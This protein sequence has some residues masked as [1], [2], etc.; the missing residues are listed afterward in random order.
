MKT[1]KLYFGAAYYDEY[2]PYERM[3]EDMAMMVKAGMNVIRI[4]ESTWS[5]WEPVEGQFDFTKL[6]H[7]LD[8]ADKYGINVIV[9][10]PTYAIPSWM[11]VK[12]PD[13]LSLTHGGRCL[14]GHRQNMDITHPKYLFYAERIIRKVMEITANH[15][16]VIGYQIDNETKSYDTCSSYAQKRFVEEL[17]AEYPDI[18]EFNRRFGLDYWSNRVDDWDNFPD[19]RGTINGSLSAEYKK[20][21]RRLVT[22][23]FDWQAGI[24]REY[25][26]EDQFI[27]HNFDYEWRNFS[28]GMQ[29]EVNQYEAC[30]CMDV[31]GCDIYHN[32]EDE[33]T[34][35]EISF[36]GAMIYGLKKE[37]YLVLETQA[38]GSTGWLP[39]KGQLRLQA[40]SHI[41]SGADS[42]MY[43]HWHSIHNAIESYWKGV[44]SHNLKENATYREAVTIGNE[45]KKIGGCIKNLKKKY[46]A[47]IM[48]NNESLCGF[49]EFPVSDELNYNDILRWIYDAFYRMN[50]ECAIIN[51]KEEKLSE[52]KLIVIPGLYSVDDETICRIRK[53]VSEGGN[54]LATYRSFFSDEN[55]KIR[56]HDQPYNM[57][58]V[59]NMTYDSF[60]KPVNVGINGEEYE[61]SRV[62]Y[63]MEMLNPAGCEVWNYYTHP[64]W[65][66]YAAVTNNT[67]LLGHATYIGCHIDEE[68]LERIIDRV[69]L[70]AHIDRYRVYYPI[71]RKSGI[72]D[73]GKRI[74]YYFNYSGEDREFVYEDSDSYNLLSGETVKKG[75]K[76]YL[77]AWDF[78]V[79]QEA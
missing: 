18:D 23:F 2:M 7:M 24:I 56:C 10:T 47:A 54:I 39:Y 15:R 45:F 57:T 61:G 77:R 16:A 74:V 64:F 63:W 32:T 76:Y 67:F 28:H 33:L 38:Q 41:A 14:Y 11:A 4:A 40:Y 22:E 13:I 25:K 70:Q 26:R 78:I 66:E 48:V 31:C 34:G 35:C 19:I 42:V 6:I 27:T 51:S 60:T 8:T 65:K 79:T 5:T 43:W 30:S 17:K 46:E 59:F 50:V 21:Q 9:G 69:L 53:Y 72:N 68:S 75:E 37:N 55:I 49:D 1:D 58:D 29:P 71:I 73:S 3:E 20:F 52:Y 44:L 36:G 12:Y 62:S